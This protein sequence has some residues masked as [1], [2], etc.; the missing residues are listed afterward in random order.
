[1]TKKELKKLIKT[2]ISKNHFL[3]LHPDKEMEKT[4]L[5]LEPDFMTYRS[6]HKKEVINESP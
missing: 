1:M 2:A 5:R 6:F 3:I 4:I